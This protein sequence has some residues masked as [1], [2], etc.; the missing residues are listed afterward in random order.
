M[1]TSTPKKFDQLIE[2]IQ[3]YIVEMEKYL[4]KN[5][6]LINYVLIDIINKNN[7]KIVLDLDLTMKVT[8]LFPLQIL[9]S[10]CF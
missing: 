6:K 1:L 7:E 2:I 9:K 4:K 10:I 3:R 8:K 5:L